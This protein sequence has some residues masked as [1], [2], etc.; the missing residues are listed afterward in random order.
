MRAAGD[1]ETIGTINS[2]IS[3]LEVKK[4]T[5]LRN[6]EQRGLLDYEVALFDV[7]DRD[8]AFALAREISDNVGIKAPW[9]IGLE[10]IRVA[11]TDEIEHQACD[12][13]W[14]R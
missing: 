5:R 2:G 11:S 9:L 13:S 1:S 8:K 10:I 4:R 12:N 7:P 6:G 14:N 3:L